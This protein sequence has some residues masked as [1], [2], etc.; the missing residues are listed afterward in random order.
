MLTK[1]E[2]KKV[3]FGSEFVLTNSILFLKEV[4]KFKLFF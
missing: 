4:Y 1:N 3:E 2:G